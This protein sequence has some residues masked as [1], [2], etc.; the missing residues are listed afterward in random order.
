MDQEKVE[1]LK[2]EGK[3]FVRLKK[4]YESAR[5]PDAG[6]PAFIINK[7]WLTKYKK[8]CFYEDLKYN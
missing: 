6:T 7:D 3:E 2:K 8:Y 5:Y 1:A 4:V